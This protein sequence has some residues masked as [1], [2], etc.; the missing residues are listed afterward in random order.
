VD[1]QLQQYLRSAASRGRDTER[2]GPFLATFDRTTDHP[3]LNY[4]MPDDG[5]RATAADVAALVDAYER[6]GRI[7]RLE[8]LPAVAPDLEAALVAGGFTVEARLPLMTCTAATH[9]ALAEPDAIRLERPDGD[10]D[11]Y[12]LR[13]AQMAAFGEPPPERDVVIGIRESVVAGMLAVL[14]RDAS[15]GAVVGGGVATTPGDGVTEIAGI[16]VLETHRRRGI[17]GA[18]TSRLT[19]DAFAAGVSTAFLTPGDDDA[20]SVYARAG[21]APTT[22]M[23]HIRKM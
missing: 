4:A 17:A 15:T 22:T 21:Y 23:L 20:F 11:L 19:A 8:Y 2:V 7:P 16:G 9:V 5:A 1:L 14:A 10:D 3:F 13:A 12:A 18:I 6:R